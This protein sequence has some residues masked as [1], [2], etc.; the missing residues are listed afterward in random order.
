MK[1]RGLLAILVLAPLGALR[2]L[3]ACGCSEGPAPP[4]GGE[5]RRD[6]KPIDANADVEPWD[7]G[8][9]SC[10]AGPPGWMLDSQ[11]DEA[12]GFCYP[13]SKAVLPKPIAWEACGASALPPSASCRQIVTDWKLGNVGEYLSP[14]HVGWVHDGTVTLAL[15]RFEGPLGY[16]MIADVDGPVRT[17]L[18]EV[19]TDQCTL[20]TYDVRDGRASYRIYSYSNSKPTGGG[21]YGFGIDEL[22]P[23][24]YVNRKSEP[25]TISRSYYVSAL[26]LFETH[27]GLI[28]QID[29]LSG[30][31]LRTIDSAAT[32]GGFVFGTL[33][34]DAQAV[35][36]GGFVGTKFNKIR[37]WRGDD[38]GA[39]DWLAF[40][41]DWSQGAGDFAADDKDM[42]WSEGHG[43][44]N[45]GAPFDEVQVRTAPRN[46][47]GPGDAG[48]VIGRVHPYG[49]GSGEMG[50][51]GC[52]YAARVAAPPMPGDAMPPESV[53]IYRLSDGRR[54]ELQQSPA[55]TFKNAVAITCDE[56]FI[57]VNVQADGGKPRANIVRIRLDSLGA[58]LPPN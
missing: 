44:A 21:A 58:G 42:I 36:W 8:P 45:A 9:S 55:M 32:N 46:D 13:S 28:T 15:T 4:D 33:N 35:F 43:R 39:N 22:K 14:L 2:L 11:Y 26:G 40:D 27:A 56:V 1:H 24:L 5:E 48:R 38:A 29:W 52:G 25:G 16:R 49:I 41:A 31:E 6:A 10:P 12:C 7:A 23:R 3:G 18:L 37:V 53:F 17:S 34:P 51:V 57:N 54:W 50:A 30:K 20:G 19:D 47:I